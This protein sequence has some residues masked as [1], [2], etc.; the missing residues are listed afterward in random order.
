MA[1]MLR[2]KGKT[3]DFISPDEALAIENRARGL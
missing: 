3:F 2:E 1:G